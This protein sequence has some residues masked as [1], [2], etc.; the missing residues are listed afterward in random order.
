MEIKGTCED[1]FLEVK[2]LFK[3]LHESNREVGSSFSV[4]KDGLPLVDIWEDIKILMKQR[5]GIE[6]LLLRSGLQPKE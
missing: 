1:N 4:Y 6:I 5:Y 3:S 2:E